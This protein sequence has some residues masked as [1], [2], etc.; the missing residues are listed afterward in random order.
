MIKFEWSAA[1][2]A[3]NERKHGVSFEEAISVFYDEFAIQF[4]DSESSEPRR[5]PI[6]NAGSKL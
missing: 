6:S 3:S 1:K 4:F 2:A 5:R